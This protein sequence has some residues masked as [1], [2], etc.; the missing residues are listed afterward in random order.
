MVSL[1]AIVASNS[2]IRSTLPSGLVAVFVG[3]T[4]G[5]GETTVRQF[6]KYADQPRVYIIG[7]SQEA[8]DRLTAE[9]A[10]INPSGT[11]VFIKRETTLMRDVDEI[12]KDLADREEVINLLLLSVG[13]LQI[14]TSKTSLGNKSSFADPGRD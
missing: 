1:E 12:C 3:G 9:C 5:V 13:T 14:G 4:N 6:T 8:G 7:R 2:R 11:Y 10:A